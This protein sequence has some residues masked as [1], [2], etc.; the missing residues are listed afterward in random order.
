MWMTTTIATTTTTRPIT[1]PLVHA[2]G[3]ISNGYYML[4]REC[5]WWV[6]RRKNDVLGKGVFSEG[7]QN[8][9]DVVMHIGRDKNRRE[10]C[11]VTENA[12]GML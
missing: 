9:R 3:V 7:R 6:T 5:L 12:H 2:C 4:T 1:L 8:G 11:R 10:S